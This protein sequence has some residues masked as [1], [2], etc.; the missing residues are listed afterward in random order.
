MKATVVS[1]VFLL[2]GIA[3]LWPWNNI[4]TATLYFQN[5]IFMVDTIYARLFT[6]SMMATSTLTSL[7]F[8]WIISN[9][10]F[11][12]TSRVIRGLVWQAGTF[13]LL[14]LIILSNVNSF[15]PLWLIFIMI[16]MLISVSA[17]ATAWTQNGILAIANVFGAQESQDVMLGQAIAGVAPS[18]VLLLVALLN[19]SE[20]DSG[21]RDIGKTGIIFYLMTTVV[22]C[23]VSGVLF[24]YGRMV[25]RLALLT[26]DKNPSNHELTSETPMGD[27][28]VLR[29]DIESPLLS[30]PA[31]DLKP[32]K[33]PLYSLYLQLKYLIWSIFTTFVITLIFPVFATAVPVSKLP[34]QQYQFAPLVFTIWNLGD[35]YGRFLAN[36]SVFQSKEF[37]PKMTFTYSVLRIIQIPL[38]YYFM[39]QA[40]R[41]S[42]WLDIGYLALQFAFG[43]TNGHII[44]ICFMKVPAVLTNAAEKEAAGGI[45]TLAVSLGLFVGSL[46][47]YLCVWSLQQ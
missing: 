45:T 47:S 43:V 44:S 35:L 36:L 13:L 2:T 6:S 9:R 8:N 37:T 40:G 22:V 15:L 39:N 1:C 5:N 24:K 32:V 28:N 46:I 4:L 18:V 30:E 19:D 23:A 12:Y 7:V 10:Q 29:N 3:L 38:F 21:D 31:V 20:S 17:I 42:W 16:M 26:M 11:A 27:N 41:T 34:L 33:I 14:T 25:E